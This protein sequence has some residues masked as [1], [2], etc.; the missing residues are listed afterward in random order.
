[1]YAAGVLFAGYN[2]K[3]HKYG[4]L[5]KQAFILGDVQGV[6]AKCISCGL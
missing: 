5:S 3:I 4:S 6:N 1:M 2:L